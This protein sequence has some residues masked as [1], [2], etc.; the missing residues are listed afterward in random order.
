MNK[1]N[2]YQQL[3]LSEAQELL[4]K[5]N[6][7]LL[8]LEKEPTKLEL[9]EELMRAAHT[10]KGS[11]AAMRY[12]SLS[13]TAHT[14]ENSFDAVRKKKRQLSEIEFGLLFRALDGM[15]A[16]LEHIKSHQQE[17]DLSSMMMK[18]KRLTSLSADLPAGETGASA[19]VESVV[20]AKKPESLKPIEEVKVKIGKLDALMNLM[21]ELL[22]NRMR[23]GQ[24]EARK[25]WADLPAALRS[26]DRLISDL[27][28]NIMQARLIPVEQI[29]NRFP[30]MV[31]DLAK[32]E[33]KEVDFQVSGGEIEL[34]R[35]LINQIGEPLVHLLRNAVDHGI[36]KKGT[37]KLSARREKGIA[38][39]EIEDDGKGIDW[40]KVSSKEKLFSGI[41]TKKGVSKVS[42]RGVGL[43]VVRTKVEEV[44][45]RVEVESPVATTGVGTKFTI[46]LPLTL[47][48]A[49]ALLVKAG[50]EKF[51]IP[52]ADVD[53]LVRLTRGRI[54]KTADM[55]AAVIADE[56]VPLVRLADLFNNVVANPDSN[57][58]T[59]LA[60]LAKIRKQSVGFIVDEVLSEQ[61]IVIKPLTGLL[62]EQKGLSGATILGDGSVVLILDV[63]G[64]IEIK[65][66]R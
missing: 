33:G 39:I 27:Q 63:G 30:R 35:T 55:E 43:T 15:T 7:L 66:Q 4:D 44:D 59:I 24:V 62:R 52:V 50:E 18:L 41:S 58:E 17:L 60:V 49:Q 54:K 26:L 45:G 29:F 38:V 9:A 16:S 31:R 40:K 42:G 22:V 11:A 57:K 8:S 36:E 19:E 61:D 47:A 34:D 2:N 48:I 5:L 56:D 3:F 21:E 28:Y 37:I 12:E 1:G 6:N 32:K 14:I 53:R 46:E 65:N 64:L 13:E 23:L 25:I 20:L 51:A 10:L